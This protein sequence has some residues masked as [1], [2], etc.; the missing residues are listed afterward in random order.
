MA[1][2][3]AAMA[4]ALAAMPLHAGGDGAIV[5]NIPLAEL[6]REAGVALSARADD[7]LTYRVGDAAQIRALTLSVPFE[8]PDNLPDDTHLLLRVGD[9]SD[10]R[11]VH[12]GEV[13]EWR[14]ALPVSA[15]SGG[16]LPVRL[17]LADASGA[18]ACAA[19]AGTARIALL[20]QMALHVAYDAA[21]GNDVASLLDHAPRPL[22]IA[23]PARPSPDQLATALRLAAARPARFTAQNDG[24]SGWEET[25]I[26]FVARPGPLRLAPTSAGRRLLPSLI[27]GSDATASILPLLSPPAANTAALHAAVLAAGADGADAQALSAWGEITQPRIISDRGGW[28]VYLP[29]N[30]MPAGRGLSSLDIRLSLG[31]DGG[32]RPAVAALALNGRVL[33]TQPVEPGRTR[34]LVADVPDGLATSM[35]RIDVTILRQPRADDCDREPMGQ[36]ARLLPESRVHFAE[37][38][39]V[40]DFSDLPSAFARGVTLVIP[41]GAEG[42][43][44]GALARMTAGLIGAATPLAVSYDAMPA[45]GPVIWLS[46]TPPPGQRA[47]ISMARR[48]T[49]IRDAEGGEIFSASDL[50]R[51]TAA[52]LYEQ[53]GR[54]VLWIRPGA[55]FAGLAALPAGAELS[56]GDVALF[57]AESRVFAMHSERE[58]MVKIDNAGDFHPAEWLARNRVAIVLAAWA[59]ITALFA[60]LMRQTKRARRQEHEESGDA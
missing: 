19:I 50:A 15:V 17:V 57:D 45:G 3:L 38:E 31:D 33:T 18:P 34:R 59:A 41:G 9:F 36:V 52:Q 26:T 12:A 54:P 47:P 24:L 40:A 10:S 5:R 20:P 21:V 4:M 60:W 13:G 27:V 43:E 7:V 32:D 56:Y 1:S 51:L 48:D 11:P 39:G 53:E 28:T 25:R 55:G 8:A 37:A 49:R 46:R 22:S 44:V 6:G 29:R 14:V 42:E 30:R 58:R 35:N 2:C 23:M 16:Y